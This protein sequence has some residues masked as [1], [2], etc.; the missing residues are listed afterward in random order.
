LGVRQAGTFQLRIA[1]LGRDSALLEQAQQVSDRL[2]EH[3]P[4]AVATLLERW[5]P[6]ASRI[7]AV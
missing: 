7:A 2:L 4:D 3:H 1:D 6:D 5:L